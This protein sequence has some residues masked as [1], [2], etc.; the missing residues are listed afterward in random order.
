MPDPTTSPDI[1]GRAARMRAALQQAFA[2]AELEI[3]D[4]SARHAGH[5]GA[6]PGG[7]THF[8]VRLT[9]GAFEG[10][11]RVER[12]RAVHL[13]LAPEF[14]RGLHALSLVLRVADKKLV[15]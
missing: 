3:E 5:A 7:E 2:P 14:A 12:S 1:P 15:D 8:T 11:S 6:A 13:A 4:D 10:M 9:T